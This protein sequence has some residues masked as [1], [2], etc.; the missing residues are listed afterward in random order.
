MSDDLQG[1]VEQEVI[2]TIESFCASK[3]LPLKVNIPENITDTEHYDL[4]RSW[5]FGIGE[6]DGTL[7]EVHIPVGWGKMTVDGSDEWSYLFDAKDRKRAAMFFKDLGQTRSTFINYMTRYRPLVRRV[8][9]IKNKPVY[10]GVVMDGEKELY[11]TKTVA[12][13]LVKGSKGFGQEEARVRRS[14][15][16]QAEIWVKKRYPEWENIRAYWD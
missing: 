6:N 9:V 11:R 4:L 8:A 13:R 15:F 7:L 2:C 3:M 5:G 1:A 10:V 16:H 14:L 12:M